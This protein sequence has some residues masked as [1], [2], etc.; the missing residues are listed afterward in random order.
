[1]RIITILKKVGV[2]LGFG[3]LVVFLGH[4]KFELP[5]ILNLESNF[6]EVALLISLPFITRWPIAI[7]LPLFTF[8]NVSISTNIIPNTLNH[9]VGFLFLYVSY[10]F[11][12][13]IKN[14]FY[15]IF[16]W[17]ITIAIYYFLILLPIIFAY[18]YIVG[19]ISLDTAI[20]EYIGT[21]RPIIFEYI[22]TT[23]IAIL[24]HL[25]YE[26]TLA[27]RKTQ[28]ELHQNIEFL[29][30]MAYM[31]STTGLYNGRQLEKDLQGLSENKLAFV[32]VRLEGSYYLNHEKGIEV[33]MEIFSEIM[34]H[35]SDR[36]NEIHTKRPEFKPPAP[37][38]NFY[39]INETNFIFIVDLSKDFLE[40]NRY[41]N[42]N[43]LRNFLKDEIKEFDF[44]TKIEFQGGLILY[45]YDVK[46]IE[47][48]SLHMLN[49][50]HAKRNINLGH[51]V[52]FDSSKHTQ[53]IQDEKLKHLI[54]E[55]IPKNEFYTVFQPKIDLKLGRVYGYEALARWNSSVIGMVPPLE[56]IPIAEQYDF[57]ETLTQTQL[58]EVCRFINELL[59]SGYKEFKVSINISPRLLT[60][61]FLDSLIYNIDYHSSYKYIELEITESTLASLNN[62]TIK[63]ILKLKELGIT[64]SIDDFGTG[65][66]NL[67]NLQNFEPEVL[68]IDKS[69]IDKIPDSD[70]SNKLVLAIINMA[71][72]LNMKVVAEGI[73]S[74][75]QK[76]FLEENGCIFIQG[77]YYSKPLEFKNAVAFSRKI[78]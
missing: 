15:Y 51:F 3:L 60:S 26:E 59:Y 62:S 70:K 34:L 9:V 11:I 46:C 45:P 76:K 32:G 41:L 78:F 64:I 23:V 29:S 19:E 28:N 56:F 75:E 48:V 6:A 52:L 14:K 33:T 22:A 2:I 73:E 58:K 24:F 74:D 47:D 65:Y 40:A 10:N 31:D 27:R 71:K 4:I 42:D 37:L 63:R 72:N 21:T 36:F 61:D 54:S 53:Y 25:M 67:V 44:S 20:F 35:M 68:K 66:S 50:L 77:Y 1:M 39:R 18:H 38:K 7:I 30:K 49:I 57:I 17:I 55:A 69:F 43:F 12:K 5:G 16:A 13:K 8:L